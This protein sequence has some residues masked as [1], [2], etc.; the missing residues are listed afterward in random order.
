MSAEWLAQVVLPWVLASVMLAMGLSL[1]GGD[2]TRIL[3]HPRRVLVGLSLQVL[4]LPLL[5]WA[6]V[7]VLP[8]PALAAAGLLLVALVPGGA[9]SNMFSFLVQGD[10]A[11]SVSLTAIAGLLAPFTLPL[12]MGWNL[13][14]LGLAEQGFS[15]PYWATVGQLLLVTVVP[16]LLGMGVR[17]LLA[18]HT[19]ATL[20]P[21]VKVFT[22]VAMVTVV[23]ALFL[24]Y[25]HRLPALLSVETLAVLALCV[26]AMTLGYQFA[27]RLQL[28]ADSVRAITVEVGVQNAGIAMMV[29]FAILQLPQL[30]L[31]PLLYGILM[32]VPVFL[33][34]FYCLWINRHPTR[35]TQRVKVVR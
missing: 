8:L 18:E 15:L 7:L 20:L 6:L 24:A 1:R 2:F 35:R 10:L 19:V 23:V 30:G 22:G 14:L 32:N 16:A 12:I 4:A 27:R 29:A 9:T 33:W 25:Q 17:R 21:L 11:L 3:R 26:S 31:V 13:Q 28:P 5:A 34:V